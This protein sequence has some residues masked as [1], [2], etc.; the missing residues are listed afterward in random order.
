MTTRKTATLAI[1]FADI[2]ES[3][4]L[5]EVL[6]DK[7][8]QKVIG[9]SISLLSDVASRYRGRVIKTIGD[10]VM[11]AFPSAN[12]AVEA[13]KDM[14]Q[15][16][17][18]MTVN[19]RVG[20]S[21][22]NIHV[23]IHLGPV[24]SEGGD[25]FG[26]AVNV[27]ARMVSLAK[28]RQIITTEHTVE[29]LLP[30]HK[31]SVRCIDKITIKGKSVEVKV[32]EVVWERQ[33]MTL[34]LDRATEFTDLRTR[35]ELG[36]HGRTI[37]VDESRP[38]VTLGR[39]SHNDVVVDDNHVS[40]THGRIEYRRGKFV[41]VDHSTNG[42]YVLM[43]GEKAINLKRGEAPLHG[44]GTIGLGRERDPDSPDVIHFST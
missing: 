10:E 30:E 41:L 34:M 33:D 37:V 3:I 24:I 40:R 38:A 15:A 11:C 28:P 14:H 31:S 25:I 5:Y 23:G 7:T 1:L 21:P 6:G 13:A 35:L 12:D 19:E 43:Q 27:A 36:F 2:A 20:F 32:Y 4:H 8:A 26:D 16:L 42:T 17:G 44:N 22:P 39:Q 29:A 18:E 9:T